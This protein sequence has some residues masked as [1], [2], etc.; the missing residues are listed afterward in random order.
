[1]FRAGGMAWLPRVP[2]G[3]LRVCSAVSSHLPGAPPAFL[4]P[5]KKPPNMPMLPSSMSSMPGIDM[6]WVATSA[7]NWATGG[8]V[9]AAA[10]AGGSASRAAIT[11]FGRKVM[12]GSAK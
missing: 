11:R 4:V 3:L 10:R 12:S 5:P 8:L 6:L 7:Q 2:D 9:W 1:M